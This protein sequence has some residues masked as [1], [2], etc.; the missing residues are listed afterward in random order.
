[1]GWQGWVSALGGVLTLLG[2][3]LSSLSNLYLVPIGAIVAI[4]FGIW[5]EVDD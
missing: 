4:I 3:Y 5:A 2:A 1:M